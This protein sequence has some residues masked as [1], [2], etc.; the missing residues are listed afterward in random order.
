M[1][2]KNENIKRYNLALPVDVFD[3]VKDVAEKRKSTV[4]EVLRKFVKIGLL[5][6]EIEETPGA[7]LYIREGEAERQIIAII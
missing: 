6:A 5:V 4:L 7:S 2:S 1:A 3:A